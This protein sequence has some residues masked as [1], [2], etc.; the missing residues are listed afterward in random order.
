MGKLR[1]LIGFCGLVLCVAC[2]SSDTGAAGAGG[3]SGAGGTGA[4]GGGS[5]GNSG[6]AGTAGVASGGAAG[7]AGAGGAAAGAAGTAGVA[8]SAGS[9]GGASGFGG[10][11]ALPA[12][13][14]LVILGDS[15]SDG[16]GQG[17]FYYDLLRADLEANYGALNYKKNAKSGSKTGALKGQVDGLPKSLPGPVAVCITSGGNDMK[18]QILQVVAG[19]DGPA[20][21]QM[22]NNIAV[23]LSALL[24]PGRFGPGVPV[25]VFEA[26]IYDA[27]DGQGNFAAHSCNFGG[28]FPAL[29]TDGYFKS[30]NAE[31]AKQIT[32]KGQ[33]YSSIHA[34]FRLHGFNHPPNWYAGDCTHPNALGHD[35]LR[36]FFFY[37]ITGKTL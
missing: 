1:L 15:I 26:D 11:A 6:S 30:W 10:S 37:K 4:T 29:P 32:A 33:W 3:S 12:L 7:S 8:G 20:R 34:L 13:G 2:S 35:Q 28:S 36:R 9:G 16:G 14:S 21:L 31:I 27:S 19:L 22:G 23:A 5:A 25:H 18:D 17:P 24:A